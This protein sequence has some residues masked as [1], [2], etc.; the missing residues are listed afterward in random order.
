VRLRVNEPQPALSGAIRSI[1]RELSLTIVQRRRRFEGF[2]PDGERV[3]AWAKR[4]LAEV[5]GLRQEARVMRGDPVGTLRIGAI[6]TTLPV[7]PL[8]TRPVCGSFNIC[9]WRSTC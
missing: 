7:L 5:D 2:T 3:L 6:P 8:L 4:V 1:E 9:A